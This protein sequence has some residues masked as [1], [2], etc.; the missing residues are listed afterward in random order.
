LQADRTDRSDSW[1]LPKTD[2]HMNKAAEQ[3]LPYPMGR[4]GE[5]F[6][7]LQIVCS[8]LGGLLFPYLPATASAKSQIGSG[9]VGVALELSR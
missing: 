3:I 7:Q 5:G 1:S 2:Y 6:I 4:F 8:T 9:G